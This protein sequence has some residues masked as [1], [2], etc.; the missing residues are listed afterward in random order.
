[1]Y[2]EG[3]LQDSKG[4]RGILKQK[5]I[6]FKLGIIHSNGTKKQHLLCSDAKGFL[7]SD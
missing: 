7:L 2:S 1:M 4:I 3:V 5:T 6:K